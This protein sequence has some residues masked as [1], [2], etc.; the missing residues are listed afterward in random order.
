MKFLKGTHFPVFTMLSR[1]TGSDREQDKESTSIQ[2]TFTLTMKVCEVELL[3]TPT[4]SLVCPSEKFNQET[5]SVVFKSDN[6][7]L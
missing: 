6:V 4:K 2:G 1:Q 5:Y 3:I 7:Y